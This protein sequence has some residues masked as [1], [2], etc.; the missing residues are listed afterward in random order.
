MVEFSFLLKLIS[1]GVGV[2]GE[3]GRLIGIG[4]GMV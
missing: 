4:F 2:L 3:M 1:I